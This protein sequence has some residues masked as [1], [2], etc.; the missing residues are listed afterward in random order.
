MCVAHDAARRCHHQSR[1]DRCR[2]P[3]ASPA[4]AAL[5]MESQHGVLACQVL[6]RDKRISSLEKEAEDAATA[7]TAVQRRLEREVQ[8]SHCTQTVG[9]PFYRH[10]REHLSGTYRSAVGRQRHQ[11]IRLIGCARSVVLSS[12][13]CQHRLTARAAS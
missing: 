4:L 10:L 11:P 2:P 9:A 5:F 6:D 8:Q 12:T 3:T 13:P 1:I 7:S